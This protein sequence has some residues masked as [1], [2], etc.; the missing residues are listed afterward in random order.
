MNKA[1]YPA[2]DPTQIVETP[3]SAGAVTIDAVKKWY[4]DAYRPDMTTVVVIGDVTPEQAK[5]TFEK[6]FGGWKASG[7]KPDVFLPAVP[8]E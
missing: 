7:A 3:E 5:A 1:L 6:Y 4:A 8:H 2:G